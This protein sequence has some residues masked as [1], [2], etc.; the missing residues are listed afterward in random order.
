[1]AKVRL[2]AARCVLAVSQ[3]QQS[4]SE[5]LPAAMEQVPARDK[6]LLQA[7][8]YQTVRHYYELQA[9]GRSALKKPMRNKDA[10]V[11]CLLMLGL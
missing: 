1:M 11:F 7:M 4:L 10:D 9:L 2:A 5:A 3:Q 8:V 6:G